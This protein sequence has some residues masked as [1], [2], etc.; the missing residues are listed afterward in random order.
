MPVGT[1]QTEYGKMKTD[2]LHEIAI[3]PYS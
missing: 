2:M 1:M 3:Q